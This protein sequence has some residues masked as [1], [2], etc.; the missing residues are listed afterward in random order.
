MQAY[1][2]VRLSLSYKKVGLS[3]DEVL[4]LCLCD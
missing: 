4:E 2:S 1:F 3:H